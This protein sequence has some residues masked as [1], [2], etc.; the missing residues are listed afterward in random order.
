MSSL[1][2]DSLFHFT[3]CLNN[4][5]G[6][7]DKTFYPRYCYEKFELTR[8]MTQ[9][10]SQPLIEWVNLIDAAIPMVCFSDIPL[11]QLMSHI[12]IY[13]KYGLGMSK[14]WGIREGLN[15]VIYFNKNSHLA[16]KINVL[17]DSPFMKGD[18]TAQAYRGIVRYLKPYM[19]TLYRGGRSVKENVRFYD[20]H[21]WRYVPDENILIANDIKTGIPPHI[22]QNQVKLANANRK[23]EKDKTKLSFNANDIK[24]IIINE[25]GQINNMVK[26]LRNIKGDRYD[27]DTIDRLISRIIT[28]K[29]IEN[30]F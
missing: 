3:P 10:K 30:D 18:S 13:G 11:S 1:S 6:I 9:S 8:R 19:G 28:V 4:L 2:P 16:K 15:P 17:I 14:E 27:N 29:Q 23:L 5:I 26:E 25:E 7:L 22:Y 20:E 12:G 24:Y 21:E